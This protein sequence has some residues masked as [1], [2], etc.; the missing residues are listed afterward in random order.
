MM[1]GGRS[2]R[3]TRKSASSRDCAPLVALVVRNACEEHR[4]PVAARLQFDA[5]INK[6]LTA[7]S[8][9][10]P[11]VRASRCRMRGYLHGFTKLRNDLA[12]YLRLY[13]TIVY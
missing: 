2:W 9:S 1:A 10:A 8:Y 7:L 13:R 3:A 12:T 4:P 11:A 6:S 5:A